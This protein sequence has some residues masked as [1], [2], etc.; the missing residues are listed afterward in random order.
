MPKKTIPQECE[1]KVGNM[2]DTKLF[3]WNDEFSPTQ[4]AGSYLSQ[5]LI[6]INSQPAPTA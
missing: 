6:S 5:L 3:E 1:L 4:W 2:K